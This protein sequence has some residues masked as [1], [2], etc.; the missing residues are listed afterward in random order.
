V[1]TGEEGQHWCYWPTQITGQAGL[2]EYSFAVRNINAAGLRIR[3]GIGDSTDN[4]WINFNNLKASRLGTGVSVNQ[5][6]EN[7]F[8]VSGRTEAIATDTPFSFGVM[9]CEADFETN[10]SGKNRSVVLSQLSISTAPV[11]T[12]SVPRRVCHSRHSAFGRKA[13]ELCR[14]TGV[15]IGALHKPFDLD[16][17]VIYLDREGTADLKKQYEGDPRVSDIIQVNIVCKDNTYPF[18]DTNAFD[19]V[20]NSH[21]LEHVTNPGRQIEEWLRIIKPG[22]ILYMI[23]P[24]KNFCFDRRRDITTVEHLMA[25][26]DENVSVTSIDHYRDYIVNTNGE[27]GINRNTSEEYIHACFEAQGS[28][29]VH[30]FTPESIN[31]F[32]AALSEKLPFELVHFE[33]QGLNMHCALKKL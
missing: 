20:I 31:E 24:D 28:I 33:P 7:L 12:A 15:E 3:L 25:E 22:G 17:N 21:V 16:A 13:H 29:H 2:V 14:G 26:Y 9:L 1:E 30:T 23:V 27:D 10:Y 6:A 32:F 8:W 18:F 5:V 19:F 4:T 11:V